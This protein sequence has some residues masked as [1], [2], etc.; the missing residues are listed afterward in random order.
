[1]AFGGEKQGG[2]AMGFPV[3]PQEVKRALGQGDV[4]VAMAL[5]TADVQEPAWAINVLDLK[6]QAFA[7]A[8]AAGINGR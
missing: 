4:A 2:M 8:Q 5:A 1:V 3:L 7:Q 6:V